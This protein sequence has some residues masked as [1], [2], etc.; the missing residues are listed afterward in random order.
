MTEDNHF[1]IKD[2]TEWFLQDVKFAK[3]ADISFLDIKDHSIKMGMTWRKNKTIDGKIFGGAM[4]LLAE[5]TADAL[6]NNEYGVY[7]FLYRIKDIKI[8]YLK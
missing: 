5:I 4:L 6:Y 2:L 7:E 3:D 8:K 1:S